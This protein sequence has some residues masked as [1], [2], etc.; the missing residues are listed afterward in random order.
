MISARPIGGIT[1]ALLALDDSANAGNVGIE[2]SD[3]YHRPLSLG[4]QT[5]KVEVDASGN[6]TLLFF[7][8]YKAMSDNVQPGSASAIAEFNITY[9]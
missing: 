7:A 2:L 1:T 8:R 4:I 9:Y 3:K 5:K 6:A